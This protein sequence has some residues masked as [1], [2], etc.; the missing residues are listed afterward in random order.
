MLMLLSLAFPVTG[1]RGI[2]IVMYMSHFGVIGKQVCLLLTL[3]LLVLLLLSGRRILRAEILHS[4]KNHEEEA[5][6]DQN[7]L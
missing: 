6:K 7:R 1:H 3:L 5:G 2:I 4:E